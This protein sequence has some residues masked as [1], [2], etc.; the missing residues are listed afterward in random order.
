VSTPLQAQTQVT[1][2][3]GSGG[4]GALLIERDTNAYADLDAH[5]LL[6]PAVDAYLATSAG[7]V[8]KGNVRNVDVGPGI[9][10]FSGS[11]TAQLQ[12]PPTAD[13]PT[14]QVLY[15]FNREGMP[16]P[17]GVSLDRN[18]GELRADADVYA[19]VAHSAYRSRALELIYTPLVE[20]M[21]NGSRTTYGVI[22][23]YYPPSAQ[24]IY[25]VEPFD[26][27]QGDIKIELYRIFS[28][29]VSNQ[30]GEFEFPPNYP[31]DGAYPD[32]SFVFDTSSSLQT[33]RVH[34]IGY[35]NQRGHTW[36]TPLHV[37][38][39][40]PYIGAGDYTPKLYYRENRLNEKDYPQDLIAKAKAFV[41]SKGFGN[42]GWPNG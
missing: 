6:F 9:V 10:V 24:T 12:K 36:V 5:L 21:G 34:E 26:I 41:A 29:S 32:R 31:G 30:D 7:S 3:P 27:D 19:A 20:R 4:V 13:A 38:I 17:T 23:A 14:F 2:A 1:I 37:P 8:R 15:A 11:S 35:I 40:E 16:V 42:K 18:T 22:A 28:Y 33:E 39:M 25:Q